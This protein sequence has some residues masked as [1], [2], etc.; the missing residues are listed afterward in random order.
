MIL[1]HPVTAIILAHVIWGVSAPITKLALQEIGSNSLLF[2]RLVIAAAVLLPSALRFNGKISLRDQVYVFLSGFFGAFVCSAFFYYALPFIPSVNAPMIGAVSPFFLAIIAGIFLKERISPHKYYGM[3][4]GFAGIL[5]VTVVPLLLPRPDVLGAATWALSET[6]AN[7]LLVMSAI[8]GAIGTL[9]LR[10]LRHLPGYVTAFWQFCIAAVCIFPF[11]LAENPLGQ[12]MD[13]SLIGVIGILY[14]GLLSSVVA[15]VLFNE[16]LH[17]V[18]AGE[19]GMFSYIS[20]IA[21]I[22]VAAPLLGEWPHVWF[23]LG[24]LLVFLGVYVSE[25]RKAV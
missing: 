7:V 18:K 20:P 11:A 19:S 1:R 5:L 3:G 14:A 13:V 21:A 2:F 24:S 6:A 23:I 17:K 12:L 22:A 9:F 8:S 16:S 25:R 4:I 10:N 15:T